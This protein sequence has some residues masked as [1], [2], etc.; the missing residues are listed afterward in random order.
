[1]PDVAAAPVTYFAMAVNAKSTLRP[2][3]A[4]VSMKGT[5]YSCGTRDRN[6]TQ[7]VPGAWCHHRSSHPVLARELCRGGKKS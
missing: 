3:L 6:V 1:M 7:G 2:L 4:L 5:P